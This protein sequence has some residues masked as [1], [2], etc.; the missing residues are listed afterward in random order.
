M[1]T[2]TRSR[3]SDRVARR[4][5][6][7]ARSASARWGTR[8]QL[9]RPWMLGNA[10]LIAW[11]SGDAV[12]YFVRLDPFR[13]FVVRVFGLNNIRT[14]PPPD[15]IDATTASRIIDLASKLPPGNAV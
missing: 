7:P 1:S 11:K 4:N 15:P 6:R 14:L 9:P 10:D 3:E 12:R 5:V 8:Q 2:P 13:A